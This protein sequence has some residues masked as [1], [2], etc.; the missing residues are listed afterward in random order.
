MHL[1]NVILVDC[2]N[3]LCQKQ[4]LENVQDIFVIFVTLKTF[5]LSLKHSRRFGY[6][7]NIQGVLVIFETFKTF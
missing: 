4:K 1:M 7:R 6:L 5:W 2:R 3:F